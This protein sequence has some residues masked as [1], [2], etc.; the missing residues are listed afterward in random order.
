MIGIIIEENVYNYRRPLTVLM[1]D[2][3]KY[4]EN[5]EPINVFCVTCDQWAISRYQA[6]SKDCQHA[7]ICIFSKSETISCCFLILLVILK[8]ALSPWWCK[9]DIRHP[10]SEML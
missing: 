7:T 4:Q 2:L 8:K 6:I 5:R 3:G 9:T 10:K 1:I